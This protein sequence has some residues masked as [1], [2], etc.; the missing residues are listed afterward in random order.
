MMVATR[1]SLALPE[2]QDLQI[3]QRWCECRGEGWSVRDLSGSGNTAAVFTIDSP[4]GELAL[5]LYN[6]RF[7]DGQEGEIQQTRIDQQLR[8]RGHSC[9]FLVQVFD[10]GKF[11][12]RLFI[13]MNR[14]LGHEL[15]KGLPDIPRNKIRQ[16]LD[17]ITKAVI[18]LRSKN[19]CHRDIKGAN[20]FISTNFEAATLLDVSVTRD[21]HDPVGIGTDH[22]GQLPI[23]ATARYSPPEY[24][25]RL[26]DPG[27]ELWHAL[28]VYQLG[29]LLHDLVMR[30]PLFQTEY[31][32]SR[33]NRYRFAW[34]VATKT[35]EIH[36]EDVDQ[37]LVFLARRALDKDWETRSALK[38]EEF[39]ADSAIRQ[40]HSLQLLGLG[41][42]ASTRT[43]DT[44]GAALKRQRLSE[45]V[46]DVEDGIRNH[47]RQKG[48]TARHT[49]DPGPDDDSKV[50]MISWDAPETAQ[51]GKPGEEIALRLLV[52]VKESVG[53]FSFGGNADLS[54]V[55]EGAPRN[56]EVALPYVE[57]GDNVATRLTDSVVAALTRLAIDIAGARYKVERSVICHSGG[58]A[59]SSL[60]ATRSN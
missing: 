19:L 24:L 43:T 5:K 33:E 37:D 46:R 20:I 21:I 14:A 22:N 30:E 52:R 16:I 50:V 44:G 38:L 47:L 60:T 9:P 31:M 27:P 48:V 2:D 42:G 39:L 8:L 18:F 32:Q 59:R 3:A 35:P 23:V 17:Q 1:S 40:A 11:E 7:S 26:L 51:P 10:G 29:A 45:I 49:I 55:I 54:A 12:D 57:D 6:R 56:S 53:G 36:A 4:Q 28:D 15:E 41:L 25:F 34:I 58:L 13:L